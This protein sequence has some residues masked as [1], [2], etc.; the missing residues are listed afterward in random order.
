VFK[1]EIRRSVTLGVQKLGDQITITAEIMCS[2]KK[3]GVQSF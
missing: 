2:K 3:L 1:K